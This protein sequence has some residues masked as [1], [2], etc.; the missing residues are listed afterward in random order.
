MFVFCTNARE[1]INYQLLERD[2]ILQQKAELKQTA[3]RSEQL[4]QQLERELQLL[5]ATSSQRDL[6]LYLV[7]DSQYSQLPV[8]LKNIP[9]VL[10]GT[11]RETAI[12][13]C[14]ILANAT[15]L[16]PKTTWNQQLQQR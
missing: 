7:V 13:V 9:N 6:H 15:P 3:F 14:K 4:R 5:Q 16:E 8:E 11:N 2:R 10:V 12:A 1:V